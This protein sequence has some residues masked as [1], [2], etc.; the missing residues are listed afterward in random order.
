LP[1]KHNDASETKAHAATKHTDKQ[2]QHRVIS[3]P[4]GWSA[5]AGLPRKHN[6][7]S[8]TKAHAATKNER[9]AMMTKNERIGRAKNMDKEQMNMNKYERS[10]KK[11]LQSYEPS[12]LMGEDLICSFEAGTCPSTSR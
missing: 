4:K 3:V 2:A 7:A 12:V 11:W 6:E 8:E 10:T 1:R 9:I 5:V